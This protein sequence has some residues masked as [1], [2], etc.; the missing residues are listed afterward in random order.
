MSADTINS[1]VEGFDYDK[2][3][4]NGPKKVCFILFNTYY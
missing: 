1:P 3:V 2:I 4:Q